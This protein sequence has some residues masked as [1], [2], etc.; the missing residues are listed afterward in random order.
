MTHPPASQLALYSRGDLGFWYRHRVE[1]H[2]EHCE[3]CARITGEFIQLQRSLAQVAVQLPPG[4]N[5]RAWQSLASEMTANIHLGLA[6]GECVS[7]RPVLTRRPA[8]AFA[9]AGLALLVIVAGFEQPN[10]ANSQLELHA[11]GRMLTVTPPA[12]LDVVRTVNTRG[13]IGTRYVDDTGVTINVVYAS[14]E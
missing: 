7:V 1:H 13:D 8:M 3:E 6:A 2:L 12:G 5:D 4:L 14:G 9:L 10:V 11:S